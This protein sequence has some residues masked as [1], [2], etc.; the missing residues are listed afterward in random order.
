MKPVIPNDAANTMKNMLKL[1][2]ILD[3][4]S[5]PMMKNAPTKISPLTDHPLLTRIV[6]LKLL[7]APIIIITGKSS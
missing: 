1:V 4:Y 3:K 5:P 2:I 7:M 6:A